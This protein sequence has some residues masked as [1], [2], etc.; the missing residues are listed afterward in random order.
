MEEGWIMFTAPRILLADC[1]ERLLIAYRQRL[2]RE[3]FEIETA[4]TAVECLGKLRAF[5]PDLLVL[6][7]MIRWGYGEGVLCCMREDADVPLVPVIVLTC[8]TNLLDAYQ[9]PR[10]PILE[11]HQKPMSPAQLLASIEHA[12]RV[13]AEH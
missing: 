5:Q 3:G 12:M 10:Y 6:E 2:E 1:D 9:L 13:T 7:P 11:R 4:T 8:G